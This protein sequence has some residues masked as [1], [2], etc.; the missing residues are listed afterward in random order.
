MEE[1]TAPGQRA[2][3]SDVENR[4]RRV[5]LLTVIFAVAALTLIFFP[6]HNE[7]KY[8]EKDLFT[9]ASGVRYKELKIGKG[10][11]ALLGSTVVVHYTGY[12]TDGTKFDSSHDRDKPLEFTLGKGEVIEGFDDGVF[13]MKEGG[14]RQLVIPP[15]AGYG[16][17]GTDVIPPNATLVFI[18]D[19]LEVK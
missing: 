16:A 7:Y 11:E 18:V 6:R 2:N 15:E 1:N 3:L 17:E 9:K 10:D 4:N 12:L 13:G 8:N 19:L 14:K 5:I